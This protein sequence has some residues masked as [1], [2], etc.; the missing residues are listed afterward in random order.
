MSRIL[1]QISPVVPY[2]AVAIG[3]YG[4]GSAWLAIFSYHLGMLLVVLAGKSARNDHK[5]NCSVSGWWYASAAV[6]ALGGVA[7]YVLWPYALPGSSLVRERLGSFG[8]TGHIWPYFAVY[9]CL[10]N[11]LIEEIF[12]RGYLR[13]DC[14]RP[15]L[16]DFAFAG[17]HAL[18]LMAFTSSVWALLTLFICVFAAWLWRMMRAATGSLLVPV[19]TH[20]IADA[21]IVLAVHFRVFA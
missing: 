11:S 16:H 21:G 10:A 8:I 9:F 2:I 1:R 15:T 12:W 3:L 7:L 19:I 17:Y 5:T 14:C 18:V 20:L 6:F 13:D 4:L